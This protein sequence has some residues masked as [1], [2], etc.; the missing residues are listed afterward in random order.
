MDEFFE[1]RL[2]QLLPSI[3][4]RAMT[5]GSDHSDGSRASRGA[6][7]RK[8]NVNH[9]SSKSTSS[10]GS[11]DGEGDAVSLDG[12]DAGDLPSCDNPT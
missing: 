1:S 8:L 7:R 10:H 6:K 5:P 3:N 9:Q 11:G 4:V 2:R 12:I